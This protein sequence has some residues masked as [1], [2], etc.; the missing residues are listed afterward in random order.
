MSQGS[1]NQETK[2]LDQKVSSV[3]RP[4]TDRH[5]N[6]HMKVN[7]EDSFFSPLQPIIKDQSN[8]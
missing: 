6:R 4:Q 3:A 1:H 2:F 5:T 7:T 8:I